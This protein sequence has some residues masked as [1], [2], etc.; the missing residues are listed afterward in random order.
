MKNNAKILKIKQVRPYVNMSNEFLNHMKNV[1]KLVYESNEV[2][3]A[4]RAHALDTVCE[5]ELE[6]AARN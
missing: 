4:L 5:I 6:L 1:G 2:P 3:V